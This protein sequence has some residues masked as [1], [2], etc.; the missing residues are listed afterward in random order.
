MKAGGGGG[1]IGRRREGATQKKILSGGGFAV[2]RIRV[3]CYMLSFLLKRG[4]GSKGEY[5]LTREGVTTRNEK[6]QIVG[7]EK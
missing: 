5:C 7:G 6:K 4:T 2:E 1:L 3:R